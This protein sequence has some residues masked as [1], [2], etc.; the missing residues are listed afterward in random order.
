MVICPKALDG[1]CGYKDAI[2]K[3]QIGCSHYREHEYISKDCD[4]GV[5]Y[6]V[7]NKPCIDTF[8]TLVKKAVEESENGKKKEISNCS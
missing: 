4:G 8:Q 3:G 5:G 1:S 6:K 7:C 2:T